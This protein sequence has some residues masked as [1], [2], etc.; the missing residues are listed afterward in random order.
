[1]DEE[2]LIT[3]E[4]TLSHDEK[5]LFA[6]T[7][8]DPSLSEVKL[9]VINPESKTGKSIVLPNMLQALKF[10]LVLRLPKMISRISEMISLKT[11]QE[12]LYITSS[13]T[14]DVY[15]YDYISDSLRLVEFHHQLVPPRKTGELEKNILTDEQEFEDVKAK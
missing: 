13:V 4:A 12:K 9:M 7:M 2:G 11:F 10:T 15:E 8:S 1:V 5:L 14:S 3:N 6:L